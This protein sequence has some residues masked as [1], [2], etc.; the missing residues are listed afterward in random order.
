MPNRSARTMLALAILA[1]CG[2]A[3]KDDEPL[4]AGMKAFLKAETARIAAHPLGDARS[5]EEWNAN[6]PEAQ[7]KMLE[8]LGLNPMPPRTDLKAEIRGVVE[9][10]DFVVERLVFQSSPGL[11]V[12]AN[13][14]RPRVVQKPLPAIVYVCVLVRCGLEGRAL[15][16]R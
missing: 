3:P 9:A 8:M 11:Y 2:A 1:C 12:T 4:P 10:P 5:A 15:N 14:Y 16:T 6:R 13:L 7:R